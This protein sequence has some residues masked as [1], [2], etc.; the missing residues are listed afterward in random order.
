MESDRPGVP[1]TKRTSAVCR[2]GR[3]KAMEQSSKRKLN[4][5][6]GSVEATLPTADSVEWNG[7]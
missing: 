1:Q 2:S 4:S 6:L 7:F 3:S 5:G